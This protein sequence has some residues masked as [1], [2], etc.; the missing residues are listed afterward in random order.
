NIVGRVENGPPRLVG[1]E[2]RYSLCRWRKPPEFFAKDAS[3]PGGPIQVQ[4]T[5]TPVPPLRGFFCVFC[6]YRWLTP[7]AEAVPGL[8]PYGTEAPRCGFCDK[9]SLC[10]RCV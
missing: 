3:R 6:H 4:S 7:P 9:R 5:D 10:L 8:R 2:G 1:P